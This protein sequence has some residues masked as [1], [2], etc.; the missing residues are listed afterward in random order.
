[1]DVVFFFSFLRKY[2]II[3]EWYLETMIWMLSVLSVLMVIEVFFLSQYVCMVLCIYIYAYAYV[4]T[5]EYM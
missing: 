3:R 5:Y 4:D 2:K 1:M